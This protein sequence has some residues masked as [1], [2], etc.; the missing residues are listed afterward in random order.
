MTDLSHFKFFKTEEHDCHYLPGEKAATLFLDPDVDVTPDI[1]SRLSR[2][3]FRRSGDFLYRPSCADCQA[4]LPLRIDVSHFTP[5]RRFR[6]IIK[7]NTDL[8]VTFDRLRCNDE[9][10]S[11]YA[12][13]IE[14]RHAD[15]EM[16]PPSTDQFIRFLDSYWAKTVFI[17][18]RHHDKLVAVSVADQLDDGLS[19]V[20]SFFDPD[21]SK[22]SLG[23]Y[24]IL[25]QIHHC[26]KNKLPYLYL[27]Y[28]VKACR[29]MAYKADFG[30]LQQQ[31]PFGWQPLD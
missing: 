11:L 12:R 26:Q 16:Y 27:G 7:Q 24:A 10:Y 18:F 6:R 2:K 15:G 19:A 31:T 23:T 29:K 30:P 1:Q 14:A 17:C 13:Y 21:E 22:R 8:E 5:K 4:C 28:L 3:G 25:W 20:Y 9:I